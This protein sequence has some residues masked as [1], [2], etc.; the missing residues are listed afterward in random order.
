MIKFDVSNGRVQAEDSIRRR[1]VVEF[2]DNYE[3][4]PQV[5]CNILMFDTFIDVHTHELDGSDEYI[6]I[7]EGRIGVLCFDEELNVSDKTVLDAQN[8][9]KCVKIKANEL[10][11]VVCLSKSAMIL[12]IKNTPYDK[13]I[14][15]KIYAAEPMLNSKHITLELLK[16]YF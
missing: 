16:S 5:F 2:H 15:K 11:T 8:D 10:H 4:I 9:S 7:C 1:A 3:Q 6:L 13:N 12:E 14:A